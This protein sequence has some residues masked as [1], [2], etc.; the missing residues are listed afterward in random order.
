MS[1]KVPENRTAARPDAKNAKASAAKLVDAFIDSRSSIGSQSFA[2]PSQRATTK[3]TM[4]A[5]MRP[6]VILSFVFTAPFFF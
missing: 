4:T 3:T 1:Q 2:V 6:P 5:A